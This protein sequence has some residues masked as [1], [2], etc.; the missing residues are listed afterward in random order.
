M[1]IFMIGTQRSGSNLLRLMLDQVPGVV[2]PHPP[3]ILERMMPLIGQYGDLG[4]QKNF[5]QLVRDVCQLVE[6]NPVPWAGVKLNPECIIEQCQTQTLLGV[7][8][9]IYD[10]VANSSGATTWCCKS[11]ANV[12]YI[13]EI[14]SYFDRPKYIYIYRDGRDVAVSFRKA[15]VGEKHFYHIAEEWAESQR[16]ALEHGRKIG[17]KRF[18]HMCYEDLIDNPRDSMQNLCKFLGFPYTEAMLEFHQSGDAKQAASASKLW[19]NVDKP[20]QSG[21]SGKFISEARRE[22]IRI[23]ES[24]AGDVLDKL[25]YKRHAIEPGREL[26]FSRHIIDIFDMENK[27]LKTAIRHATDLQDLQRRDRQHNFIQWVS[28][29]LQA[30]NG[31]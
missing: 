26:K 19:A 3:H 14:E 16:L 5:R 22:D 4:E 25:G 24:I 29:R 1:A 30:I 9:A 18:F 28:S 7:F 13:N 11:L 31:H 8:E 12:Q 23:F 10:T 15:I 17:K 27:Q 6:L 20:I 21:N 2:A